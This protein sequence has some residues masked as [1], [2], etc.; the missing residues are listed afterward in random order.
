MKTQEHVTH[1]YLEVKL[2]KFLFW[3]PVPTTVH[4]TTVQGEQSEDTALNSTGI[5]IQSLSSAVKTI[6]ILLTSLIN[7]RTIKAK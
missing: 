7:C 6:H 5:I 1:I 4:S 2:R 3:G